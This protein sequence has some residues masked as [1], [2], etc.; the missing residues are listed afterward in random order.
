MNI[1]YHYSNQSDFSGININYNRLQEFIKKELPHIVNISTTG[2]DIKICFNR[3]LDFYEKETL[4]EVINNYL[5]DQEYEDR[6]NELNLD[7]FY[8]T[9]IIPAYQQS[10]K[11][12]FYDEYS[13]FR[14]PNP[15]K[16]IV[17]E[18]TDNESLQCSVCFNNKKCIAFEPCSHLCVCFEC[19]K[20]IM[21]SSKK[22]PICRSDSINTKHIYL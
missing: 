4:N 8:D 22:C 7:I 10:D 15:I 19:S 5:F 12:N 11:D 3:E 18:S 16:Q 13:K 17:D 2:D 14:N 1:Y 20:Q 9:N 21:N 6:K